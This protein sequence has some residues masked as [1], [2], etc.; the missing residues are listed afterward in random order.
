[1]TSY[2]LYAIASLLLIILSF[3]SVESAKETVQQ[4]IL[5][6]NDIDVFHPKSRLRRSLNSALLFNSKEGVTTDIFAEEEFELSF[7]IFGKLRNLYLKRTGADE[8]HMDIF[9][10]DYASHIINQDGDYEKVDARHPSTCT[11]V[12]KDVKTEEVAV[13][14]NCGN[15]LL[16]KIIEKVTSINGKAINAVISIQQ[17]K[18]AEEVIASRHLSESSPSGNTPI[19]RH[20]GKQGKENE[21]SF[22][23]IEENDGDFNHRELSA[24]ECSLKPKKYVT[25]V[26]A[27]APSRIAHFGTVNDTEAATLAT[28]LLGASTY[29]AIKTPSGCRIFI[30][31]AGQLFTQDENANPIPERKCNTASTFL[32]GVQKSHR[33]NDAC[34]K[35]YPLTAS[36]IGFCKS[37]ETWCF[38]GGKVPTIDFSTAIGCYAFDASAYATNGVQTVRYVVLSSQQSTSVSAK[39]IDYSELLARTMLYSVSNKKKLINLFQ[40]VDAIQTWTSNEFAGILGFA[41]TS[42]MCDPAGGSVGVCSITKESDGFIIW[43]HELGHNLG[44]SHTTGIMSANIDISVAGQSFSAASKAELDAYL[45]NVYGVIL[46]KC[47]DKD[48][49]PTQSPTLAACTELP[50][51]KTCKK[52]SNCQWNGKSCEFRT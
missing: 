33:A 5:L 28:F 43:A 8:N 15:G 41:Y 17:G 12:G 39:N 49:V 14:V 26:I 24:G 45:T 32:N 6:F 2:T 47:I 19:C 11:F 34:C 25:L 10:T 31:L 3:L 16:L 7:K 35:N 27:N 21:M 52:Q 22:I 9:D 1:M 38:S 50:T 13:M 51:K 23:N 20:H 44:M 18:S 29:S 48:L 30:R 4:E 42:R 36:T 37:G 40:D 46:P